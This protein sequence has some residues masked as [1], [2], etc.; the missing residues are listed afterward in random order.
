MS[1]TIS[2]DGNIPQQ[3]QAVFRKCVVALEARSDLTGLTL[4]ASTAELLH[5]N[6]EWQ[7]LCRANNMRTCR[8]CQPTLT[9]RY[10]HR[11]HEPLRPLPRRRACD[12]RP[13]AAPERLIALLT[14]CCSILD[15][16]CAKSTSSSAACGHDRRGSLPGSAFILA[17]SDSGAQG[18]MC[19]VSWS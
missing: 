4:I 19:A 15:E 8:L 5:R 3:Y 17:F 11:V 7:R 10:E 6:R 13:G 1:P 18:C 12:G 2:Q 16:A 9:F 14:A